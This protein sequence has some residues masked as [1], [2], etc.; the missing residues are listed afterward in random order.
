MPNPLN[1]T[2]NRRGS[3]EAASGDLNSKKDFISSKD[4][5]SEFYNA[6]L[7]IFQIEE[8]IKDLEKRMN[9]IMDNI[10]SQLKMYNILIDEKK[11]L[12]KQLSKAKEQ[13]IDRLIPT[14]D[15]E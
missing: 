2:S 9:P 11:L 12:F 7:R 10:I 6:E 15:E 14:R 3:S 1:Y 13:Q 8:R 4:N 5:A